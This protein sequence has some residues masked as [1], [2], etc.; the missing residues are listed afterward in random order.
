MREA[1]LAPRKLELELIQSHMAQKPVLRGEVG[2]AC[3]AREV[4]VEREK[5]WA[6][7]GVQGAWVGNFT[8]LDSM[9]CW[10]SKEEMEMGAIHRA[11]STA[12]SPNPEKGMEKGAARSKIK[13]PTNPTGSANLLPAAA[14][15]QVQT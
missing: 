14:Q 13:I 7:A 3:V 6:S 1:L 11:C 10:Y 4:S 9:T 15:I 5:V 8:D 2:C 12:Q